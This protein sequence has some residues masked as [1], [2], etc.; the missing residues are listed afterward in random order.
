MPPFLRFVWLLALLVCGAAPA[1]WATPIVRIRLRVDP[2]TRA[3]TCRYRFTLPASDTA[4]RLTLQLNHA[5][6]LRSVR[7][8]QAHVQRVTTAL[9]VG[10][11]VHRVQ[12]RYA[13]DVARPR[14]VDLAYSGT[15]AKGEFT[16]AVAVFSGHGNWLPFR[17]YAEYEPV[18]YELVVQV[19]AAYAVRS[20]APPRRRRRG[21]WVFGGTTSAIEP[22]A[23]IARRFYQGVSA[24]APPLALVKAGAPLA[25][26]D[27]ALL[28]QA[29]AIVA[30][31]NRTIGR[32]APVTRFTLL[33][34]GTNHGAYGLLDDAAVIT[35]P[36][37]DV[38]DR[39]DL[40]ILAH[41]ISH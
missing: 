18:A 41:E 32:L 12:V 31:Y 25:R 15:L 19:P 28:R 7:S 1:S 23:L 38:A 26:A 24:T 17:P 22:T 14:H 16:D 27:T 9:Y 6:R 13:P 40:L 3:F 10:D 21:A 37:F 4:S 35:Y 39:G 33:L 20:T 29:E 8:P 34:P 5:L 30:F 36:T 11:T 2:R